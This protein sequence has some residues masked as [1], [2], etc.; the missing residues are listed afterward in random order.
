MTLIFKLLTII[1]FLPSLFLAV[2]IAVVKT[3]YVIIFEFAWD[4]GNDWHKK[5]ILKIND[6]V[7][8]SKK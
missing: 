2:F 8:K 4:T 5:I 6:L 7:Q 3:L 1:L